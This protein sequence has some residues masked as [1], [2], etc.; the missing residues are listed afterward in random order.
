MYQ[1]RL[2]QSVIVFGCKCDIQNL[3]FVRIV[4]ASS[5]VAEGKK[6]QVKIKYQE[7]NREIPEQSDE[8]QRHEQ[9]VLKTGLVNPKRLTCK[10]AGFSSLTHSETYFLGYNSMP[11]PFISIIISIILLPLVLLFLYIRCPITS[12]VF[13]FCCPASLPLFSFHPPINPSIPFFFL[14]SHHTFIPPMAIYTW[15][16]NRLNLRSIH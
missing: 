14:L 2:N 12:F 13:L 7:K 6:S 3:G 5:W 9:V 16:A 4:V 15:L 8:T 1:W 11:P 10:M